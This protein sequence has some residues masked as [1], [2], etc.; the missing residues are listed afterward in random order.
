MEIGNFRARRNLKPVFTSKNK[1]MNEISKIIEFSRNGK[2]TLKLAYFACFSY[3]YTKAKGKFDFL[4]TRNGQ[5]ETNMA[6]EVS[7]D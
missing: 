2:I 3:Q 5:N 4:Y 7:M 1:K 6:A